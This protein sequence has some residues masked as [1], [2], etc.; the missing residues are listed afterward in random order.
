[1]FLPLSAPEP[2]HSHSP[3]HSHS[4]SPRSS[5]HRQAAD[6]LS[7]PSLSL[8]PLFVWRP[9][10]VN[11]LTRELLQRWLPS[12]PLRLAPPLYFMTRRGSAHV[13]D[14]LCL[15]VCVRPIYPLRAT[16]SPEEPQGCRPNWSKKKRRRQQ[17][18]SQRR[19]SNFQLDANQ[20]FR[21][22]LV[23]CG[24]EDVVCFCPPPQSQFVC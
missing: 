11:N 16:Q 8:S 22:C 13:R 14:T 9:L 6:P 12:R 4:H 5:S 18:Q 10:G 20:T 7:R 15:C 23:R 17:S 19:C 2:L 21:L 3:S 24:C 1:M